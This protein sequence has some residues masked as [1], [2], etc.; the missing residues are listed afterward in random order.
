MKALCNREGLLAAFGMVSGV[1]PARSP[2]PILQNIKLVA[3]PEEG[4]VLMATDLEVGIRHRVL[5]MKVD[6]PGSVILPTQRM[7]SILRTSAD[8]ELDLEADGDMLVVRGLHAEFKLPSEDPGLYPEVPDFAATS[9]HVVAAADL[10]KLIRRTMFAT[11]VESTRYAL[12]GVLVELADETIAMVGTDGRRL[13]RMVATAEAE[14]GAASPTGSPV[15]PVKA[16]KLIERN[17]DDDDP[18]VHLAIQAGAAVLVR[19]ERAVIY[20]RLVEGRFPRYQ[21]VFPSNVEVK[22]PLEA[23]PLRVAVE[24]ASIVTSE[25]SRGVDF[26]FANGALTLAS[27]AADVGSSHVDLPIAYDGKAIEITFDPRYLTDALRTLDDNTAITAELID[28]KNA[29][30]FK[31]DDRY[32]YVVMPLTRDR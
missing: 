12:G 10:R 11:D 2:K 19:T 31:T 5:G 29:A 22:I 32:T 20:S 23:G 26:Q 27:Q 9:Y 1:A 18:P 7:A 24:Q 4:S 30:V 3:D 8:E 17:L 28:S 16:L 25:E 6:R 14:N 21:D 13:A 15:I